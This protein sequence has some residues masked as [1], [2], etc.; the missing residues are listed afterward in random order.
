MSYTEKT[1]G[2]DNAVRAKEALATKNAPG[3]EVVVADDM[4][5][6]ID[7]DAN[8][9][10]EQFYRIGAVLEGDRFGG[11]PLTYHVTYSKSGNRHVTI[12]LPEPMNVIERVAWQAAFGSDPLREALNLV[13]IKNE[14]KNPVLLFMPK[15]SDIALKSGGRRFREDSESE[16]Q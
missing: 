13:A 16:D 2:S 15:G 11:R 7:Y 1:P 9:I 6:Q 3:F 12:D 8:T 14:V 5:L 10:P 4:H